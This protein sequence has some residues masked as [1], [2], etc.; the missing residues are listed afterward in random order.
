MRGK[1]L[2]LCKLLVCIVLITSNMFQNAK[3]DSEKIQLPVLPSKSVDLSGD[4]VC[5]PKGAFDDAFT[6]YLWDEGFQENVEIF[7]DELNPVSKGIPLKGQYFLDPNNQVC[8]QTL[9]SC[10]DGQ[11]S[12]ADFGREKFLVGEKVVIYP[13]F[14]IA[15]N[16]S[17]KEPAVYRLDDGQEIGT[18]P[19]DYNNK[20]PVPVTEKVWIH[21]ENRRT[22][23]IIVVAK[24]A[25]DIAE[26]I[27]IK[28]DPVFMYGNGFI[29]SSTFIYDCN[30]S[31]KIP[32]FRGTDKKTET[33]ENI[34]IKKDCIEYL[35]SDKSKKFGKVVRFDFSGREIESFTVPM[36]GKEYFCIVG[37]SG[38]LAL[39]WEDD[40]PDELCFR[41]YDASTKQ[42]LWQKSLSEFT[43]V[44]YSH[45]CW[46]EHE[47]L[48]GANPVFFF[49]NLHGAKCFDIKSSKTVGMIFPDKVYPNQR[50]K[51]GD[52]IYSTVPDKITERGSGVA[53]INEQLA[54]GRLPLEMPDSPYKTF[55][56]EDR[57]NIFSSVPSEN[58]DDFNNFITSY[59]ARTGL[60]LNKYSVGAFSPYPRTTTDYYTYRLDENKIRCLDLITGVSFDAEIDYN[61]DFYYPV[62]FANGE[63][64]YVYPD[65]RYFFSAKSTIYEFQCGTGKLLSKMNVSSGFSFRKLNKST[66]VLIEDKKFTLLERNGAKTVIERP[67]AFASEKKVF[68]FKENKF[69]WDLV[70]MDLETNEQTTFLESLD[71]IE[72]FKFF[73][74]G[75]Y[76]L[77]NRFYSKDKVFVQNEIPLAD[78][79]TLGKTYIGTPLR[80]LTSYA[81]DTLVRFDPCATYSIERVDKDS[82][83]ITNTRTDGL[84]SDLH[85]QLW[86]AED[87]STTSK[88]WLKLSSEIKFDSIK[89]G[90]SQIVK[91]DPPKIDT[92]KFKLV[93]CANGVMENPDFIGDGKQPRFIGSPITALEQKAV[94]ISIWDK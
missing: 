10:M 25:F 22:F 46:T 5:R 65:P 36:R 72:P 80:D 18:L 14:R 3:G 91:V 35:L 34:A 81:T 7:D 82:F 89:P 56:D 23:D 41:L 15:V 93:V 39:V 94:A 6:D 67:L 92:S 20:Y 8:G 51:V 70:S 16:F 1:N 19:F 21:A 66:A 55:I 79:I 88:G 71:T 50:E 59:D 54:V 53:L 77:G 9:L 68:F 90:E 11:S 47:Y 76:M 58:P 32:V 85:G 2:G 44:C 12:F 63:S 33:C 29:A 30:K 69:R 84:S 42:Y 87:Q 37:T 52:M 62:C 78:M 49:K 28:L 43:G 27:D 4:V 75:S 83:K 86:L 61:K 13:K 40:K 38:K 24:Y 60:K 45:S 26:R 48:D 73:D 64:V 57:I 17:L 74:D 31:L